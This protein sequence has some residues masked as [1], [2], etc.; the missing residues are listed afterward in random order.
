[1]TIIKKTLGSLG[2][3]FEATG[4]AKLNA[5]LLRMGRR[6]VED[7]GYSY[8]ALRSGPSAWPWRAEAQHS[9]DEINIATNLRESSEFK[10]GQVDNSNFAH[11][12]TDHGQNA[13]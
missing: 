1:M 7:L 4:K 6:R 5:E 9:A 13:A 8:E 12:D 3:F 10:L 2:R 11:N